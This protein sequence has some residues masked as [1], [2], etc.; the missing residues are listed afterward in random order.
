MGWILRPADTSHRLH[1]AQHAPDGPAESTRQPDGCVNHRQRRKD[2][3]APAI[4]ENRALSARKWDTGLS[5]PSSATDSLWGLGKVPLLS[6]TTAALLQTGTPV[7]GRRAAST[8]QRGWGSVL[9]TTRAPAAMRTAKWYLCIAASPPFPLS[10]DTQHRPTLTELGEEN[11][12]QS[13]DQ[14]S[15]RQQPTSQRH[16]ADNHSEGGGP[17]GHQRPVAWAMSMLAHS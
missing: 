9:K 12:L 2:A 4:Q 1:W 16:V 5:F 13:R 10:P 6:C 14:T 15:Y 7:P 3:R 11:R 17:G 8:D